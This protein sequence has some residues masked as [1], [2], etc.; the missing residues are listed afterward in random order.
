[1]KEKMNPICYSIGGYFIVWVRSTRISG[2]ASVLINKM[3][4]YLSSCN[5]ALFYLVFKYKYVV[6]KLYST[7]C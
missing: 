2:S 7:S 4:K 1:M 5:F 3:M 6:I